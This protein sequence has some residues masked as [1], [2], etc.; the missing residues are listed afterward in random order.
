M[1]P[2]PSDA[3]WTTGEGRASSR[4]V[5]TPFHSNRTAHSSSVCVSGAERLPCDKV[6]SLFSRRTPPAANG[7]AGIV[8][9]SQACRRLHPFRRIP[10]CSFDYS[11]RDK[12]NPDPH[13]VSSLHGV[14]SQ[15]HQSREVEHAGC[16]I[17]TISMPEKTNR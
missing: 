5:L 10:V 13:S 7:A 17:Q 12:T 6:R 3:R 8:F 14:V 15:A 2:H 1:L 16:L 4:P 11:K 9:S